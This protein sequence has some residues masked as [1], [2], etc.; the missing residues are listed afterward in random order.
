MPTRTGQERVAA[1]V[2]FSCGKGYDPARLQNVCDSCGL[3][4]K[5]EVALPE[6]DAASLIEEDVPSMWRY[7][8]VLPIDRSGSVS[9]GE[10]WTPILQVEDGV[11]LKD[12]SGNP[13]GSFKSRGMS[14]AVSA[15]VALGADR[16]VVPTAGFAGAALSIYGEAA[17]LPVSIAMP[18]DTP[19]AIVDECRSHG[20]TVQLVEG[21]IA[22]AG[23]WLA[24]N[25]E[26]GEFDV[27]TLKEP[28]RVEGKKTMG[29]ELFEQLEWA[30]PDVVIYP[31]GGG[32]GLVGMCK[33]WDEM[34]QMGWIDESRPRLVSVQSTGCAPIVAAYERGEP[35]TRPW[36]DPVTRAYGLRVPSP[37]GGFLCL[38]AI[39]E[40]GGTAVAVPEP[41]L[42]DTMEEMA[43]ATGVDMCPEGG[44]AWAAY[45][46]LRASG[47]I[48]PDQTV[49]VW[50]TG[51]G[52][53]YRPLEA[54]GG[55]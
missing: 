55:S 29:Y 24:E 34:E 51:S 38:R 54:E 22:D 42:L 15:A 6:G 17:G 11:W 52:S 43:A 25:R 46:E 50:N 27:S 5:V 4:L 10:G 53:S 8:A 45:R 31:T 7:S 32:T 39:R 3:P 40:T 9:L 47:W 49:V 1:L 20:A 13:G 30:L 26:D 28:Y 14:M 16:L 33:A 2:C 19:G 12:E 23:R 48:G 36:P 21:T 35:V 37:I 18:E 44:A 41:V